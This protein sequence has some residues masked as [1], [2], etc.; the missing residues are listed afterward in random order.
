LGEII[1]V[2]KERSGDEIFGLSAKKRRYFPGARREGGG[3][4]FLNTYAPRI[5]TPHKKFFK[6]IPRR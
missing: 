1:F 3:K 2:C 5:F 4:A 6:E